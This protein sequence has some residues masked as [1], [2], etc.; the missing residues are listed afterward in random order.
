LEVVEG[1]TL[2]GVSHRR[3]G[4]AALE[5]WHDAFPE[6][7]LGERLGR[8][9]V[10]AWALI[11]TCNRWDVVLVRPAGVGLDRVRSTLTPSHSARRPYAYDGEAALEHLARVAA[12]LESLN[13]GED[14]IMRQVRDAYAAARAAGRGN[15]ELA[16]A[17][18]TALRLAKQVR[19]EIALAPLHTSLFSLA[20][21]D[22]E[23]AM[24]GGARAVV[25]GAGEMGGL[26]A[27]ALR[28]IPGVALTVVNRGRERALALAAKVDADVCD[29][30]HFLAEPLAARVLVS[31]APLRGRLERSVLERVEGLRLVVDLGIP[32][33]IDPTHAPAGVRVLSVDGL[34]EAGEARRAAMFDRLAEAETL[35]RCGLDDAV[36]AWNE[37][38]LAPAIRALVEH[39]THLVG[40]ALPAHEAERLARAVARVPIKGLRAVAR[41]HGLAA[42][43]TFLAETGLP[44]ALEGEANRGV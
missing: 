22:V 36:G 1:L 43:A 8:V 27:R 40:D 39:Y 18:D 4:I 6:S 24:H 15:A 31:A 33:S 41:E 35:L 29:L 23:A 16:F 7:G 13:P 42:A 44:R 14:Q 10:R 19:R 25:L 37:R 20:R 2:I 3:G 28:S 9:G 34:R 11:A 38:A 26:A 30:E 12:S 5:S 17:F 32:R 21:A